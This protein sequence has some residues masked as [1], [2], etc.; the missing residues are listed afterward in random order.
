L[1]IEENFETIDELVERLVGKGY[2]GAL[3]DMLLAYY[4]IWNDDTDT[5]LKDAQYKFLINRGLTGSLPDMLFE[6]DSILYSYLATQDFE[7]TGTPDNWSI[8]IGTPDFDYSTTGLSMKGDECLQIEQNDSAEASFTASSTIYITAM[9]RY[10]TLPAADNTFFSLYNDGNR[11]LRVRIRTNGQL[12][13]INEGDAGYNGDNP[14]INTTV[15]V[16]LRYTKGTGSDAIAALYTSS[17]G[18]TWSSGVESTAGTS[19]LDANMAR[20]DNEAAGSIYI[21][22]ILLST[23]DI[24]DAR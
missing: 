13:L 6:Y 19:T 11:L 10:D 15:Y 4:N 14:G 24:V 17:D 1:P 22:N 8:R 21:D 5:S 12:R 16:K 2:T 9:L 7:G 18:I 3:N 20:L 23:E